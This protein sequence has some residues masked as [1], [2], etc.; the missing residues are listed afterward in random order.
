[1]RGQN[2]TFA[3]LAFDVQER[4][5]VRDPADP[6]L[7]FS[8]RSVDEPLSRTCCAEGCNPHS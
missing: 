3:F 6:V 1:M 8:T 7:K 5:V 4:E 2:A